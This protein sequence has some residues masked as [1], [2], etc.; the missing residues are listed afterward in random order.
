MQLR[1]LDS[2]IDIADSSTITCGSMYINVVLD[3]TV[4]VASIAATLASATIE[5]PSSVSANLAGIV[6][7][8]WDPQTGSTT[9]R[10]TTQ[11]VTSTSPTSTSTTS[12]TTED[13]SGSIDVTE[14]PLFSADNLPMWIAA[15]IGFVV[16]VLIIVLL[17]VCCNKRQKA[18]ER[19]ITFK[20]THGEYGYDHDDRRRDYFDRGSPN[21]EP[22]MSPRRV[23]SPNV[24]AGLELSP[25]HSPERRRQNH[26]RAFDSPRGMVAPDDISIDGFETPRQGNTSAQ[27]S[28]PTTPRSTAT[29]KTMSGGADATL[30]ELAADSSNYLAFYHE[31]AERLERYF[32]SVDK[33]R[34]IKKIPKILLRNRGKEQKLFKM[35][36]QK[37]GGSLQLSPRHSG[38]SPRAAASPQF[39][40]L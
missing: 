2:S 13:L 29:S 16:I 24:Y 1:S 20:S 36:V 22:S 8:Y 26:Q 23:G 17:A 18:E 32:I 30:S 6:F 31:N 40:A 35:L 33:P 27:S 11:G 7:Y 34:F 3:D 39:S 38:R 9:N 14:G 5:F 21:R 10:I 19:R 25:M 4:N 12:T 28:E 37:Y 15:G